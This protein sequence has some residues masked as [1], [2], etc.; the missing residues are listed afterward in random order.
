MCKMLR[1]LLSEAVKGLKHIKKNSEGTKK[2]RN[3]DTFLTGF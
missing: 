1:I 2:H 3:L